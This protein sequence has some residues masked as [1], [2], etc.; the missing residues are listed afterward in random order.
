MVYC[1]LGLN[2]LLCVLLSARGKMAPEKYL[3]VSKKLS[4]ITHLDGISG[5]LGWDEMV[6]LP[7]GSSASRGAQKEVLAGITY[8]KKADGELGGLQEAGVVR[9]GSD[10]DGCLACAFFLGGAFSNAHRA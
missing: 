2:L 5:L 4:E 8:D 6:M 10:H 1:A 9:H 7:P 3:S